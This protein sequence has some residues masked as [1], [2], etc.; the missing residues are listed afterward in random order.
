M[1]RPFMQTG[2]SKKGSIY[3]L[4]ALVAELFADRDRDDD[5]VPFSER[6][7]RP[8]DLRRDSNL[9]DLHAV[10]PA[11]HD[12]VHRPRQAGQPHPLVVLRAQGLLVIPLS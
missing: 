4:S 5:D 11:G 6:R 1:S 12:V 9:A 3:S 2:N 8:I 10:V 7:R